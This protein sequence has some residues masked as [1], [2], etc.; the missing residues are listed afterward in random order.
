MARLGMS[1]ERLAEVTKRQEAHVAYIER[2]SKAIRENP[3]AA[4][5]RALLAQYQEEQRLRAEERAAEE[6]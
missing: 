4:H 2:Q 6:G 1:D 3:G 5:Q